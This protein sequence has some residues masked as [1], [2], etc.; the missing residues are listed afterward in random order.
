M[1]KDRKRFGRG[2]TWKRWGQTLAL[3]FPLLIIW[4][5]LVG[6]WSL[7]NIKALFTW[8]LGGKTLLK[9][10]LI[11]LA[12]TIWYEPPAEEKDPDT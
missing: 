12:V 8:D 1:K 9:S 4:N 2:F 5:L 10:I 3:L 6:D 7:G 11:S